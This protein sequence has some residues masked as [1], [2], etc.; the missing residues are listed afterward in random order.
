MTPIPVS[1]ARDLSGFSAMCF[2]WYFFDSSKRSRVYG[3]RRHVEEDGADPVDSQNVLVIGTEDV[4]EFL[5]RQPGPCGCF[6]PD[7]APGC[8]A[9]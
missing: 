3:V 8:T 6:R 7:G 5:Y 4:L 9:G 1:T 2:M